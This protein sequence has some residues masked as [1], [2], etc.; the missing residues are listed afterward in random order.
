VA[1]RS[2]DFTAK[3]QT[4]ASALS[5]LLGRTQA[6]D[7]QAKLR[8][9]SSCAAIQVISAPEPCDSVYQPHSVQGAPQ[10]A[11][12]PL[13]HHHNTWWMASFSALTRQPA[14]TAAWALP[15]EFD[16][17]WQDAKTDSDTEADLMAL[18]TAGPAPAL[19]FNDF[20]A[21]SAYGTLLHDLLE[22]Q[23]LEGWPIS[24]TEAHDQDVEKEQRWQ[25]L[26]QSQ[27]AALQ[28]EPPQCDLLLQWLAQIAHTPLPLGQTLNDAQTSALV[29][30][31]LTPACA[32]AEMNFTLLTH[33]IQAQA[34]DRLISAHVLP[35]HRVSLCM[36]AA[37]KA[38]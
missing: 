13:R 29:L 7:L 8:L 25:Q 38:C 14:H 37:C 23:L 35:D 26:F 9:W 36:R 4:P 5:D 20:K 11:L 30:S 16:E 33:G 24:R 34:L 19:P 22:W 2:H 27:T 32:W 6:D 12:S 10:A 3:S 18:A 1:L 15:S 31:D 17:R 28:L 21:G